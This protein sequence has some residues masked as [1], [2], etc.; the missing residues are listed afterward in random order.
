MYQDM[1][2]VIARYIMVIDQDTKK[3][4]I[5]CFAADDE[6]GFYRINKR[7]EKGKAYADSS[8]TCVATETKKGNIKIYISSEIFKMPHLVRWVLSGVENG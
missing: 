4:I 2:S 1:K 7:N 5:G 8:K 3:Q 6:T